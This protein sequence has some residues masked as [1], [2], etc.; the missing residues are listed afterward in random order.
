M[1]SYPFTALFNL[2]AGIRLPLAAS[3]RVP[4]ANR[5]KIILNKLVKIN[6]KVNLKNKNYAQDQPPHFSHSLIKEDTSF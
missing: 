3:L 4:V 1:A 6:L 2:R 5:G